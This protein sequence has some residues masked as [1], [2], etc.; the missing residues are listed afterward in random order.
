MVNEAEVGFQASRDLSATLAQAISAGK[1]CELANYGQ[2]FEVPQA[3][4]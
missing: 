4:I 3:P 1:A 2:V